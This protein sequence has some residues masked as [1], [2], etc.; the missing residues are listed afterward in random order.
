M[1]LLSIVHSFSIL[2]TTPGTFSFHAQWG[3]LSHIEAIQMMVD[4][5]RTALEEAQAN[6]TT[7]QSQ[8]KSQVD[9]SRC[10]GMFEV[11]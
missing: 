6:F 5:M 4:W 7:T 3:V 9:R 2:A 10:H 1:S 11:G 8:A